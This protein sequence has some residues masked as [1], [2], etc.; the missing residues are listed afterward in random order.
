MWPWEHLAIGYICYALWRRGAGRSRP[1]VEEVAVL[2]I[3]TQ[4][5]DLVDK[6]LGWGTTLL[7][8]GTSLAHSLLITIPVVVG[9]DLLARRVGRDH[10]G[11][12]FGIGYLLHLPADACYAVL[13]GGTATAEF[14]LWPVIPRAPEPTTALLARTGALWAEFSVALAGPAGAGYL[15]VEGLLLGTAVLLWSLDGAPGIPRRVR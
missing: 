11:I 13:L 4:F 15:L 1:T 9:A 8:S 10:L 2:A 12:V 7:P 5:P 3:G 14:L 6:P